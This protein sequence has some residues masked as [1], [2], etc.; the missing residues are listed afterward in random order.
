MQIARVGY[1]AV[2]LTNFDKSPHVRGVRMSAF[3]PTGITQDGTV[4]LVGNMLVELGT[5]MGVYNA[6][7]LQRLGNGDPVEVNEACA[8]WWGAPLVVSCGRRRRPPCTYP[9]SCVVTCDHLP[10]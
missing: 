6:A 2:Q 7:T 8:D 5:A 9:V 3:D 1:T 10:L 4:A